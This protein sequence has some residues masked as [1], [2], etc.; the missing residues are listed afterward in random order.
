[1]SYKILVVEDDPVIRQQL[2]LLLAGSGY[3]VEAAGDAPAA[4]DQMKTFA[5]QLVLLDIGL[6]AFHRCPS[7]LSPAAT[8]TW[9]S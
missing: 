2:Q 9:T 8:P 4:L 1:M 5:P 6:P 3:Q 7:S